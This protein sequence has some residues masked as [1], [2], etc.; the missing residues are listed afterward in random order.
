MSRQCAWCV[1]SMQAA[2]RAYPSPTVPGVMLPGQNAGVDFVVSCCTYQSMKGARHCRPCSADAWYDVQA[3]LTRQ[4]SWLCY[5]FHLVWRWLIVLAGSM[6][7]SLPLVGEAPSAVGLYLLLVQGGVTCMPQCAHMPRGCW[8]SPLELLSEQ[9]GLLDS[10]PSLG[11]A[12]LN[13]VACAL[14]GCGESRYLLGLLD[15]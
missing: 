9:Q 8:A 10:G 6:H 12:T 7:C 4:Q 13:A 1:L 15:A 5:A 14:P 3:C 2:A 11:Y